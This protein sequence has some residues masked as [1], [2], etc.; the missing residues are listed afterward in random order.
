MKIKHT[1]FSE[2]ITVNELPSIEAHHALKVLRMQIKDQFYLI[3]GKGSNLTCEISRIEGKHLYFD[4]VTKEKISFSGPKISIAIGLPKS[5]DRINVFLEKVAEIGV[6]SIIPLV[7][8]NSER[9]NF[10]TDKME[11]ILISALKQSGNYYL[12]EISEPQSF[13]SFVQKSSDSSEKFIAH[14][15]EDKEKKEL[16]SVYK[17]GKSALIL[18]GP[19][20]DFTSEELI[21]AKEN[22]FIPVSLGNSRL[23]TETAGIVACHTFHVLS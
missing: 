19:E 7:S 3:D 15:E 16:K 13:D 1:F 18:I 2:D 8:K 10:K 11:N 22:D 9:Q 12:P 5:K 20:G 6:S 4:V 17:S 21:L 14:C 23:R